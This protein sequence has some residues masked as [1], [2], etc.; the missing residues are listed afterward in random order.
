[1]QALIGCRAARALATREVTE[2]LPRKQ[3]KIFALAEFGR[4]PS[5]RKRNCRH[6]HS[7]FDRQGHG[8]N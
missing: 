6:V 8:Q 7:A 5:Q 1:M 3:N 4:S 2:P